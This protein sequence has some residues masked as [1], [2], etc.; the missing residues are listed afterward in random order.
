MHIALSSGYCFWSFLSSPK[1]RVW[2]RVWVVKSL[3]TD[4]GLP[5]LSYPDFLTTTLVTPTSSE[6]HLVGQSPDCHCKNGSLKFFLREPKKW[7]I[8]FFKVRKES[9]RGLE[10][11]QDDQ[12]QSSNFKQFSL[13]P[14]II[15]ILTI[16][17]SLFRHCRRMGRWYI[18]VFYKNRLT[19]IF[20]VARLWEFF[21]Q[22]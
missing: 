8:I 20:S 6:L 12:L 7:H 3:T 17:L 2:E 5:S 22:I 18:R 11:F 13:T 1:R 16:C 15:F 9:T 4:D 19:K 14:Q 21:H 10:N